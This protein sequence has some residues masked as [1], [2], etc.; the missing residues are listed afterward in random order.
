MC[1]LSLYKVNNDFNLNESPLIYECN[2]N[3]IVIVL[4]RDMVY[5]QCQE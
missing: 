1:T 4:I 5:N 2:I 3:N